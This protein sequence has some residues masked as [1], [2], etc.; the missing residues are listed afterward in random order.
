[1]PAPSIRVLVRIPSNRPPNAPQDPPQILW[2]SEKADILW[3]V[4]ERSRS[5]DGGGADWKGLAAHLEVPLPY[6]LYRVNAR[7]QEEIRGLKDIS[8]A[9]CPASASAPSLAGR[10]RLAE[11]SAL[12]SPIGVR[13]R[14]N[15]LGSH[16][17]RHKKAASSSTIT[18]QAPKRPASPTS[19]EG[20]DSEDEQALKEEEA[21]RKAEE[22]DALDRKLQ[23]L[24]QMMT[25]DA[26]GLVSS[27]ERKGS[28]RG[29]RWLPSSSP[30]ALATGDR[31]QDGGLSSRSNST[32]LSVSSAGSPQG[33][34]PEIPSPSSHSP[35]VSSGAATGRR[36][37]GP[38]SLSDQGSNSSFSDLSDSLSAS[39]LESALLSNIKGSRSQFTRSR[40]L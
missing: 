24:Q 11:S 14:L 31:H 3:K 8:G 30:H 26:L 32:S 19:S 10:L 2:T 20:T 6:L 13:A 35:S 25:N 5:I 39:A 40:P 34:I 15:S 27:R 4:I 1:M 33:S 29:R 7:F 38:I 21:D 17:Q 36:Q 9:L 37:H 22:Q 18:V 23:E 12:P 16:S 28:E